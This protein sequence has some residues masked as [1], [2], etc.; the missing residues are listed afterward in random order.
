MQMK[1][2]QTL[3]LSKLLFKIL[4]AT[5]VATV[6]ARITEIVLGVNAVNVVHIVNP[7][8]IHQYVM[9]PMFQKKWLRPT[10]QK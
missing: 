3:K 10:E 7:A 6:P 9:H 2:Y 5:I 4:F 8:A 1:R